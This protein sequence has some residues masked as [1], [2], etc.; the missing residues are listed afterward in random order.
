MEE[1][2]AGIRINTMDDDEEDTESMI[3]AAARSDL[4]MVKVITWERVKT[5]TGSDQIMFSLAN[6]IRYGFPD[7]K[8]Q[9]D[10]SLREFWP[11]RDDL[12]VIDGVVMYQN[13]VVI[14]PDLR[15]E[16]L[17]AL[18]SAHQGTTGMTHRAQS[19]VFW[20]GITTDLAATRANCRCCDRNAP[21]QPKMPP[22][23]PHIPTTPFEALAAD[24]FHLQGSYYLV[25]GDRLSGW[26]EVKAVRASS[27][28]SGAAGLCAAL[29][30]MFVTFG[31][32]VEISSDGGPEFRAQ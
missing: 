19:S 12:Y 24:Y 14:P 27:F 3:L 18:H 9:L 23:E 30:S 4:N 16:V 6:Q 13:R 26:T 22:T 25:I 1:A 10:E 8:E 11:H 7:S 20:P 2:L 5:S 31:V 28:T 32:P 29:R 17:Q 15:K 21:S